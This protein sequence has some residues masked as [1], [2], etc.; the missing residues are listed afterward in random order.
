MPRGSRNAAAVVDRKP[1]RDRVDDL[2][3]GSV[4]HQIAAL[5]HLPHVGIGDFA[6]RKIDLGPDDARGA[7][8][9]LIDDTRS[10][11]SPAISSA[12]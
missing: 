3:V 12:A 6:R 7:E 4:P 1:D 10:I 5:Q 2:A 8:R 9:T 11:V